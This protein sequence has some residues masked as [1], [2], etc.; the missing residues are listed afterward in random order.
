[1][2]YFNNKYNCGYI[3]YMIDLVDLYNSL[4]KIGENFNYTLNHEPFWQTQPK[5]FPECDVHG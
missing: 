5:V 3:I 4:M 1:L 2:D